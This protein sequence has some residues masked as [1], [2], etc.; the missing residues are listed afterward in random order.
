MSRASVYLGNSTVHDGIIALVLNLQT[1]HVSSQYH[2]VFDDEFTNVPYLDSA[3]APPNW[4]DFIKN[5]TECAT[6]ESF[7]IASSWYE[8]KGSITD[9]DEIPDPAN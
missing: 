9:L 8:G 4:I 5:H 6:E 7:N 2:I 1:G 3:E